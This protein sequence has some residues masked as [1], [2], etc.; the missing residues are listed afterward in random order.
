MENIESIIIRTRT[1]TALSIHN[2]L[3]V[4]LTVED[5]KS[6][7]DYDK[8]MEIIEEVISDFID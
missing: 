5:K 8:A 1:D 6:P 4:H 7:I 2:K 3:K